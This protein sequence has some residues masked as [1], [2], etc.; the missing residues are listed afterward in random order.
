MD[1]KMRKSQPGSWSRSFTKKTWR[2][3]KTCK[4][5]DDMTNCSG[6]WTTKLMPIPMRQT[7][8]M[9]A[10]QR[11]RPSPLIHSQLFLLRQFPISSKSRLF[12]NMVNFGMQSNQHQNEHQNASTANT[13]NNSTATTTVAGETIVV[14]ATTA[15]TLQS[16]WLQDN[17]QS[18]LLGGGS[19]IP[20][21]DESNHPDHS[22]SGLQQHHQQQQQQGKL[23]LFGAVMRQFGSGISGSTFP[24][25]PSSPFAGGSCK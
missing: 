8:P 16:T 23:S 9:P 5:N 19:R 20:S 17:H 18:T 22:K 3:S 12:G 7:L 24:I 10:P 1:V 13:N 15:Y 14:S 2:N 6:Y 25:S 4:N 11:P 21:L